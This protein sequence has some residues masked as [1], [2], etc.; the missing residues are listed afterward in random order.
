V[1]KNKNIYA[2]CQGVGWRCPSWRIKGGKM[3]SDEGKKE[4]EETHEMGK[5]TRGNFRL[6]SKSRENNAYFSRNKYVDELNDGRECVA[7]I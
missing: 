7:L 5:K 4:K 1:K 6:T 2:R 3:D